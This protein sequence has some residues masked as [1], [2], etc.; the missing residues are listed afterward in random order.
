M[1]QMIKAT[2]KQMTAGLT[3]IPSRSISRSDIM[4]P[5]PANFAD[6]GSGAAL[7]SLRCARVGLAYDPDGPQCVRLMD[8]HALLPRI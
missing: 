1:R 3:K 2:A 6:Q 8:L 4:S 7:P 5:G